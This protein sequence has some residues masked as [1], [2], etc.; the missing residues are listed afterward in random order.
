MKN[1]VNRRIAI[2]AETTGTVYATPVQTTVYCRLGVSFVEA[3]KV[4][5]GTATCDLGSATPL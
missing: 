2:H 4:R 3:I 5:S 1:N